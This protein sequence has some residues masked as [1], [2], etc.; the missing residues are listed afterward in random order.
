MDLIEQKKT[1]AFRIYF[2]AKCA[3]MWFLF[4]CFEHIYF[5][6]SPLLIDFYLDANKYIYIYLNM[7]IYICVRVCVKLSKLSHLSW[8]IAINN[9][10]DNNHN[11]N[12]NNGNKLAEELNALAPKEIFLAG[13][14][15]IRAKCWRYR[16]IFL[17]HR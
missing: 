15:I 3:V 10:K 6:K 13:N 16:F 17:C 7:T 12:N 5:E 14:F 4:L 1:G 8:V 9:N 11:H 2:Y